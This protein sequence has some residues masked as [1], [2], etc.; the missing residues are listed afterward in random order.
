MKNV[1]RKNVF[2]TGGS[3]GIG[4]ETA[5][6]FA[7][8]GAD[9]TLFARREEPLKT[10]VFEIKKNAVNDGQQFNWL[11]MDVADNDDIEEK[12]SRAVSEFNAPDIFINCAG[13]S[14]AAD[15]ENISPEQFDNVIRINLCGTRNAT[16]AV[17]PHMKKKKR[18]TIVVVASTAGL[19]PVYGYTAYGTSKYALVGFAECLRAEMK[20]ENINVAVLCPPEV[21][22][23]LVDEEEKTSPPETKMLKQMA[24]KLTTDYTAK[25]LIKGIEKGRFMII[26][27]LLAKMLYYTQMFCP[28]FMFRASSDMFIWFVQRKKRS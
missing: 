28:G 16:A 12:I 10:A 18:G 6:Q 20:P 17:V 8:K 13:I 4:L 24:G 5:K 7:A 11:L 23:P 2:I 26:P 14:I 21:D 3:S 19:I 25:I 27:G 15:F 9:V 22:T 1:K